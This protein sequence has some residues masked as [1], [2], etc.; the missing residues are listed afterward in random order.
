M[1]KK[2]IICG[3]KKE[4]QGKGMCGACFAKDYRKKNPDKVKA[5]NKMKYQRDREKI[6]AYSK[7][8]AKE[9]PERYEKNV[10][11]GRKKY[12][13]SGRQNEVMRR[14]YR[15]NKAECYSRGN[16]RSIIFG[17]RHYK[18]LNLPK[19]TFYCLKCGSK[20]KTEIHHEIYPNTKVEIVQ[21]LKDKKIHKEMGSYKNNKPTSF[22]SIKN[23][24][25]KNV[26]KSIS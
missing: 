20:G 23:K 7:K 25:D 6:L 16:T 22:Q 26:T 11:K 13:K 18:P 10:A 9:N 1:I 3:E 12:I 24:E 21:A 4:H 15:R 14:Y 19:E 5:Y 2:C 8:W 17:T